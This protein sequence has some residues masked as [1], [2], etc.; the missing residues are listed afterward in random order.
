MI[1]RSRPNIVLIVLDSVRKDHLSCYGYPRATTPNIDRIA[2]EGIRFTRAYATSCWTIPSHASLFTSLYPSQHGAN[3]ATKWLDTEHLTM[4]TY[5]RER[6]YQTAAITC[7]GFISG[8]TNL[9]NGFELSIDVERLRGGPDSLRSRVVRGVHRRWKRL[10]RRDRGAIRATALAQ[11]WLCRQD[12]DTPFF[13][14]M[15]FMDCH[16][17]YRLRGP[18]RYKFVPTSKRSR[19]NR[20]PQD[21]FGYMAGEL[22]LT[23][24]DIADLQRLY[25]G[26][27]YHLDRHVGQ[28]YRQLQ[29]LGLDERTIFII[30]SDHGESFGEHGLLDHQYGLYEHLLAVPLIMVVPMGYAGGQTLQSSVQLVDVFPTV[31]S[32]L[33]RS[34]AQT[35][36]AH[37]PGTSMLE[38]QTRD[39]VLAEYLIPNLQTMRRRFPNVDVSRYDVALRAISD[40]RHKLIQRSDGQDE[41]YDLTV[42][43]NETRNLLYEHPSVATDLTNQLRYALGEWPAKQTASSDGYDDDD[44]ARIRDRLES[45]G[46]L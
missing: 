2:D 16:L 33:D 18:A 45:L 9:N 38:G 30:T 5:L 35:N 25:D 14:F 40:G 3:A 43:P 31:A 34:D 17:P 44:L 42:N 23:A 20:I 6:G 13:L 19:V 39:Y 4:A 12:S 24:E 8:H 10:V 37:L 29:V 36:L 21:P 32:L 22:P 1:R 28:L 11:E 7:N 27:L 41:L 15:N 46:Y 26:A